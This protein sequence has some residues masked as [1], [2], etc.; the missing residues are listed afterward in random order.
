MKGIPIPSHLLSTYPGT[1]L[2][3]GKAFRSVLEDNAQFF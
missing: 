1:G 2:S 3:L